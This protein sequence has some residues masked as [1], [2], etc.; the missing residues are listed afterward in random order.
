VTL[1]RDVYSLTT[2]VATAA[3]MLVFGTGLL[4]LCLPKAPGGP[5]YYDGGDDAGVVPARV[6]DM[7]QPAIDQ[8]PAPSPPL[9]LAGRA[10]PRATSAP[11]PVF[12]SSALLQ[13][14]PPLA[15]PA[16]F[17]P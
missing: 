8:T 7:S 5:A 2:L 14:A 15:P 16:G 3:S 17:L 9:D 4:S 13:R 10:L 6:T 12:R 1:G 11:P